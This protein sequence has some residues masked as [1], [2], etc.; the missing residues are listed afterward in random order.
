MRQAIDETKQKC[1]SIEDFIATL[2]RE[3][4][5]TV[6]QSRGRWSYLP[7]Y[8]QKPITSR[9]LGDDFSKEAIEA[10]IPQRIRAHLEQQAQKESQRQKQQQ[11]QIPQ[12]KPD[13]K[14]ETKP[15]P[16]PSPI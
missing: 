13:I 7:E 1:D 14:K 3:H 15:E 6:S 9:R 5:I 12:A 11:A 8:R 10:F 4:N 16:K 2:K